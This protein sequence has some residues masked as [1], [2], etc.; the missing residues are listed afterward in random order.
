MRTFIF[1]TLFLLLP[2]ISLATDY[3]GNCTVAFEGSSTLHNFNGKGRCEPFIASENAGI[4]NVP[5]LT[6]A[7]ADMDTDNSSRDN[8]MHK[9]FEAEKYPLITGM[10]GPVSLSTIRKTLEE[11]IDSTQ[12]LFFQL[13]V[14]D[15]EKPVTAIL[16][17]IV[18][19]E[20]KLT[21]DLAF[22]LS[23]ADYKL[24]APSVLG[25]IRVGDTIKVTTS[26]LLEAH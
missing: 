24:K 16:Q 17:N 20:D 2:S 15:I 12:P 5:E 21:A 4:I 18:E 19:T 6:V 13:K 10:S 25:I 22:T 11:N 9:M 3:Q 1:F 7:V 8:K 23:L 14:R 26:F